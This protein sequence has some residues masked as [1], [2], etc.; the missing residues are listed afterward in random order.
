MRQLRGN[1]LVLG[2]PTVIALWFISAFALTYLTNEPTQFGIYWPRHR[3]L[4]PH[5]IAGIVALLL[6]PAQLWLGI[7][8]WTGILHR[9]VGVLY[10][11]AVAVSS[12][13]AFYLARHTDFGWVF[14]LGLTSMA[15]VWIITT[16]LAIIAICLH[17]TEQHREWMVRSYIVTFAFVTFRVLDQAMDIARIGTV[18]ERKAVASWLAWAAPLFLTECVLQARKIFAS[19]VSVVPQPDA[20]GYNAAPE[21]RAFGLQNSGSSY[22]HQP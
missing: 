21:P 2:A 20:N 9:V 7:N 10:V 3:W 6:G 11:A 4:L 17:R 14:G 13:A 12:A 8:G 16:C 1:I 5:V 18:L 19:R 22:Q 15:S